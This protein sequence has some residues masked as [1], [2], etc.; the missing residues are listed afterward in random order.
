MSGVWPRLIAVAQ[1]GPEENSAAFHVPSVQDSGQ[2]CEYLFATSC[3][4]FEPRTCYILKPRG[5][6]CKTEV[7]KA[8]PYR[9]RNR[10]RMSYEISG[11]LNPI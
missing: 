8:H 9:Q 2:G 10:G 4:P 6:A 5:K 1:A 3:G 7:G 11:R